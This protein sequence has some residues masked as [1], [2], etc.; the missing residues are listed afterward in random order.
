LQHYGFPSKLGGYFDNTVTPEQFRS[1]IHKLPGNDIERN[2][3]F[4]LETRTIAI[5]RHI[6]RL[7]HENLDSE[8]K[9]V[10]D[11][12]H[13]IRLRYKCPKPWCIYFMEGMETE[14]MREKHMFR[15]QLPFHCHIEDCWASRIGFD[16][17]AKL[18]SHNKQ[19]HTESEGVS[20]PKLTPTKPPTLCEAAKRGD[21]TL[22]QSL[23]D[24]DPN[25]I[26]RIRDPNS[27]FTY[28]RSRKYSNALARAAKH[29]HVDVCKL[30]ISRGV[31]CRH[32]P[33]ILAD[34]LVSAIKS[35]NLELLEVLLSQP[36]LE[37][38]DWIISR[39]LKT[40]IKYESLPA[41]RAL[42]QSDVNVLKEDLIMAVGKSRRDIVEELLACERVATLVDEEVVMEAVKA[43]SPDMVRVLLS[44]DRPLIPELKPAISQAYDR[45]K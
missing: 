29:N 30:L 20:F 40:A 31:N 18:N 33:F 22:V 39:P 2:A 7:A 45:G 10:V 28:L 27:G 38:K 16:N 37:D 11:T 24:T 43:R 32:H 12:F 5:R 6:E 1:V 41:V 3:C 44:T 26:V 35:T 15:H 17:P 25:D 8:A 4:K 23:L 21:I 19:Y 42:L 14:E 13:G 34:A 9:E 36:K